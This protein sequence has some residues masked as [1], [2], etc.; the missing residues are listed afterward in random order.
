MVTCLLTYLLANL[1]QSD[2][3]G[4]TSGFNSRDLGQRFCGERVPCV[5]VCVCVPC[6][7]V[8]EGRLSRGESWLF[9]VVALGLFPAP[10]P[11]PP[12][13]SLLQSFFFFLFIL[14]SIIIK[15][16]CLDCSCFTTGTP[17]RAVLSRTPSVYFVK[18]VLQIHHWPCVSSA[19]WN[20]FVPVLCCLWAYCVLCS[21]PHMR[22]CQIHTCVNI[23]ACGNICLPS[24]LY[25]FVNSEGARRP[26][27]LVLPLRMVS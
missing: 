19:I 1:S 11:P 7:P 22:Q 14:K 24:R 9:A 12:P 6:L 16:L 17:T 13:P 4:R 26:R 5:C 25:E 2:W 10:P 18:S 23:I 15:T 8:R 3:A 21:L 27:G 20:S